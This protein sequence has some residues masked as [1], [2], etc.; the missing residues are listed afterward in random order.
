MP[1]PVI[2][3][4]RLV[5]ENTYP[6]SFVYFVHPVCATAVA[7]LRQRK[8]PQSTGWF[9]GL[10]SSFMYAQQKMRDKTENQLP[11]LGKI[12]WSVRSRNPWLVALW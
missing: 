5:T 6:I 1:R 11:V 2:T 10:G 4:R 3:T 9:C 12:S 7:N 8:R